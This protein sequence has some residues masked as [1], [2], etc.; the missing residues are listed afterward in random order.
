MEQLSEI[1]NYTG[2]NR[3]L[4]HCLRP[5]RLLKKAQVQGHAADGPFS[6]AC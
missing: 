5:G 2:S 3:E 6:A 4:E 1:F